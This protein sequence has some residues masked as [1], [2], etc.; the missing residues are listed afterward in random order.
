MLFGLFRLCSTPDSLDGI[1]EYLSDLLP[2]MV[3]VRLQADLGYFLGFDYE[4]CVFVMRDLYLFIADVVLIGY[5][6]LGLL[7]LFGTAS[8][9]GGHPPV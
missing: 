7:A 2:I 3:W 4:L 1:F 9:I 6:F 8:G 5:H